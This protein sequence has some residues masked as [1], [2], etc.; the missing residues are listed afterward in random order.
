MPIFSSGVGAHE[1][2][3]L[4]GTQEGGDAAWCPAVRS[5]IVK[6]TMASATG[7]LVIQFLRAVDDVAVALPT[8]TVCCAAASL[9][10]SGSVS[11]KQPSFSAAAKGPSHSR[12]LRVG[13]ELQHRIAVERVVHARR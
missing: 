2:G 5:V 6:S 4:V 9:P 10:A 11:P 13:A 8:A 12:L 3:V 7:P 1:P